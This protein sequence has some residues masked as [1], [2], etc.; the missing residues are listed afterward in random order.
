MVTPGSG[1]GLFV[2]ADVTLKDFK[3]EAKRTDNKGS[4]SLKREWLSKLSAQAF[5]ERKLPALAIEFGGSTEQFFVLRQAEF[6]LLCSYL[7]ELP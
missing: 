2:K 6:E 7:R 5:S 1:N 4:I 3:V